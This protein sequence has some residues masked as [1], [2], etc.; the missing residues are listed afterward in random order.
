MLEG[1]DNNNVRAAH[2]LV[3]HDPR[4]AIRACSS[5]LQLD[6]NQNGRPRFPGPIEPYEGNGG[7]KSNEN[8]LEAFLRVERRVEWRINPTLLSTRH[9]ATA[10]EE[11]GSLVPSILTT[12][13]YTT[14]ARIVNSNSCATYYTNSFLAWHPTGSISIAMVPPFSI[15]GVP[16]RVTHCCNSKAELGNG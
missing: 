4:N 10:A 11:P 9:G 12:Q 16:T 2:V 5:I 3:Q 6:H 8:C 15:L 7:G 13:V 14:E 1:D